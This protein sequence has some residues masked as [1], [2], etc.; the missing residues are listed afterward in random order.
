MKLSDREL[1]M[2]RAIRISRR[3]KSET[4]RQDVGARMGDGL[5]MA[6]ILGHVKHDSMRIQNYQLSGGH[7]PVLRWKRESIQRN[8][9]GDAIDDRFGLEVGERKWS[10]ATKRSESRSAVRSGTA[11]SREPDGSA[12]R[13]SF[14]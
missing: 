9:V 12:G 8:R 10:E 7:V 13:M 4:G 2:L 11:R 6:R 3:C 14:F 1:I 5:R